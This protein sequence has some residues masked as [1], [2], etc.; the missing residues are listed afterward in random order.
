[1]TP[2]ETIKYLEQHGHISDDVKD[3]CID[4]LKKQV[5]K[6]PVHIHKE[7]EKHQW[8]KDKNG[9]VNTEAWERNDCN[10]VYCERCGHVECVQC[11]PDYD[12]GP[13]VIDITSC[14]ACGKEVFEFHKYPY[15]PF[16]TQAL[17][18]GV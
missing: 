14:P 18:W 15:C 5:L 4:A 16:C 7:H 3:I 6:K 12:E 2:E 17:D 9:N 13:C 11:N 8:E 1:M 10:G